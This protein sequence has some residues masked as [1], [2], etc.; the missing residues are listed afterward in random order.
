MNF[1]LLQDLVDNR[2]FSHMMT[3][4]I[5]RSGLNFHHL[6][7]APPRNPDGIHVLF[8]EEHDGTVRVTKSKKMIKFVVAYFSL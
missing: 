4:K 7:I 5:A 1:P 3:W 6:E 2:V 8:T